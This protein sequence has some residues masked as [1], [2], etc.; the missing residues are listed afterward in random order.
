VSALQAEREIQLYVLLGALVPA[1]ASALVLAGA[2][3]LARRGSER[4][5]AA[6]PAVAI[7][8]GFAAGTVALQGWPPF[9]LALSIRQWLFH[10]A[11]ALALAGLL[12]AR[13]GRASLVVRVALAVLAPL[14][15]LEFQRELHWERPE[16]VAW[17]AGLA[18]LLL[19]S[20]Q[21]LAARE[22]TRAHAAS[23]LGLAL[24]EALAAA[25]YLL[26][27][28][29]MLAQLAGALALCTG[30]AALAGLAGRTAGLGSAGAG[31]FL[32]L[33]HALTWCGRFVS[34]LS[35]TGFALL[36]LVPLATLLPVRRTRGGAALLV[37]APVL[38]AAAAAWI[39]L[40][41][42]PATHGA[43]GR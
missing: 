33:H 7:G 35:W 36:A 40:C 29:Q 30:A 5:S 15:L 34:D 37:L 32:L 11:L 8:V 9:S 39:E 10:L 1:A 2:H 28:S 18:A 21:A 43:Y 22:R 17:T 4:A 31:A 19:A 41:D 24:A 23:A 13:A 6:G 25:A 16:G 3:V 38:V 27:G 20:W 26:S 12:E 42:P 14:V